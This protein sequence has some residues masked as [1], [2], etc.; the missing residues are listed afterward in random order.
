MTTRVSMSRPSPHQHVIVGDPGTAARWPAARTVAATIPIATL[1]VLALHVPLGLV[2]IDS[3]AVA[4]V[5]AILAIT[6]GLLL[7]AFGRR[8]E[9]IVYAAAYITGSDVLWR[10]CRADLPWEVGKYAVIGVFVIALFRLRGL[11]WKPLPLLYLALLLPSVAITPYDFLSVE[12]RQQLSFNLSGPLALG[13][14]VLFLSQVDLEPGQWVRTATALIAPLVAIAA[15]AVYVMS[16]S[17]GI[18][19]TQ[20]SNTLSSGG[21]GPNQV[22][23]VLGLGALVAFI[24]CVDH[25]RGVGSRALMFFVALG[26]ALQSALTF[27]RGGLYA[28]AGAAVAG[29]ACWLRDA[30]SR[31]TLVAALVLL[32]LI[33][34]LLVLPRLEEFTGGKFAGRFGSLDATGRVELA[35]EDIRLFLTHPILGVGAGGSLAAHSRRVAAHTELTRLPAEHGV[36]GV[37]ALGVLITMF[38]TCVRAAQTHQQKALVVALCTWSLLTMTHSAMRTVAPAFAFGLAFALVAKFQRAG[39]PNQ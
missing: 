39:P 28:A 29:A 8:V 33:V 24:V 2:M 22:S 30:R 19:F 17:G 23:T 3:P 21:F 38:M 18:E 26:L 15:V 1:A 5:H 25:R 9:R 37:V 11:A 34:H 12:A 4:T 27:S 32:A 35:V 20:E 6:V 31:V 7:A 13:I 10:M 14:S 16:A 36:L